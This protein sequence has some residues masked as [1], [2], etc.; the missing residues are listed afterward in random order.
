MGYN[1]R[2]CK[3][4]DKTNTLTFINLDYVCKGPSLN[5]A[6]VEVG[7]STCG[8]GGHTNIQP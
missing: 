1:S 6:T 5:T 7:T 8:F 3:E 2:G 4:S